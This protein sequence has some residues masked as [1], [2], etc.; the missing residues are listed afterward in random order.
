MPCLPLLLALVILAA[1]APSD[2]FAMG[3]QKSGCLDDR[4]RI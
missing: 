3:K 2:G 4:L 1:S